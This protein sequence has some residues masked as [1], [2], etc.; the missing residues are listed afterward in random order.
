MGVPLVT[1]EVPGKTIDVKTP[2]NEYCQEG[3]GK[4]HI[5]YQKPRKNP[6]HDIFSL[7]L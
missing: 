4:E 7:L 1:G 6:F 3:G 2:D 5:A